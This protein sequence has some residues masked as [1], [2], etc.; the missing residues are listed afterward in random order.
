M[1]LIGHIVYLHTELANNIKVMC[2]YKSKV[3]YKA[4][5]CAAISV[6]TGINAP[7]DTR[8]QGMLIHV[9]S[10]CTRQP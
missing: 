8:N 9:E 3:I 1:K 5:I 2:K 7:Q 6:C 4:I 10:L